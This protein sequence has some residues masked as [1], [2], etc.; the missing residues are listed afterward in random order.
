MAAKSGKLGAATIGSLDPIL[1]AWTLDITQA[2]LDV[3]SFE[4]GG[5]REVVAGLS[6]WSGSAEGFID[7]STDVDLVTTSVTIELKDADNTTSG[8]MKYTGSV[9]ITSMS[10]GSAADGTCTIAITFDGTG[11]LTSTGV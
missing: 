6:Q 1:R 3:T 11:A 10:Y 2:A 9:V 4:S 5:Q 8:Q 7:A